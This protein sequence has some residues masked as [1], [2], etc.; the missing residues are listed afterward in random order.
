MDGFLFYIAGGKHAVQLLVSISSLRRQGHSEPITIAAGDPE[1]EEYAYKIRDD[2][3]LGPIAVENITIQTAGT[4]KRGKS[5]QHCGK[6]SMAEWSPYDRTIFLDAD[7]LVV[8]PIGKLW[9]FP[10]EIVLTNFANWVTTGGK[11]KSRLRKYREALP[12]KVAMMASLPYPAINTG[13]MAWDRNTA[14]FHRTWSSV[15]LNH[16]VNGEPVFMG[17]EIVAN[18]IYPDYCH[19]I[20]SDLWNF[21]P[22]YSTEARDG[23]V[24]DDV[25]IWHYHGGKHCRKGPAIESWLPAYDYC[26][27]NDFGGIKAW[28][29]A[30]DR[31]LKKALEERG[32]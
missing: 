10:E 6:S 4:K 18:L 31:S 16:L 21:S 12:A 19:R 25:K 24:P 13:V 14:H 27:E 26:V 28:T 3:R 17:D 22:V 7:T 20:M 15:C 8:A 23:K 30:R 5:R 11:L 29:P 32:E 2:D 1:G 9:P